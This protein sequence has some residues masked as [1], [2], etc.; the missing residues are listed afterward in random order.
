MHLEVAMPNGL[1][2]NTIFDLDLGINVTK[3]CPAPSTPCYLCTCKVKSCYVQRFSSCNYK[4]I[5]YVL[6]PGLWGQGQR[7][8]AQYLLNNVIDAPIKYDIAT[9]KALGVDAFTRK[10]SFCPVTLAP[11]SDVAQCP[12]HHVTYV[13]TKFEVA[14]SKG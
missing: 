5:N 9:S 3:Y 13:P 12:L 10:Y 8:V 11:I 1:G 7:E 4:E 14:T 2:E 6:R